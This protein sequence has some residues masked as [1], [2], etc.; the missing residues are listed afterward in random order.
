MFRH[1]PREIVVAL[2]QFNIFSK[3]LIPGKF[4]LGELQH[5]QRSRY[6]TQSTL[7][8]GPEDNLACVIQ[9]VVF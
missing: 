8:H 1:G 3:N 9:V 4:A 5:G 6:D 7:H 2:L